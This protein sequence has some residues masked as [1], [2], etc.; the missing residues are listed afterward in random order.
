M[1][2]IWEPRFEPSEEPKEIIEPIDSEDD[3][4]EWTESSMEALGDLLYGNDEGNEN[5]ETVDME[6]TEELEAA[7]SFMRQGGQGF[8]N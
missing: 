3:L 8:G 1:A 5:D 7:K 4:M 2:I 6:I